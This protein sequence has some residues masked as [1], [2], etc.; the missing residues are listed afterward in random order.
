M[1]LKKKLLLIDDDADLLAALSLKLTK[2]GKF[3]VQT[4]TEGEQ[5]VTLAKEFAPDLILLDIDMPEISG[6]EVAEALG[7]SEETKR[8]PILFL[9]SL[10]GKDDMARSGGTSGKHNM[11]SK[12]MKVNELIE[13]IESLI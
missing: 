13:R 1:V 2:S 11:A 5:A 9:S 6:P 7:V 8:I 3:D 12:S 10:V 4:S